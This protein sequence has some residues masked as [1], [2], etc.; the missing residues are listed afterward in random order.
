MFKLSNGQKGKRSSH[1]NSNECE[2]ESGRVIFEKD[3]EH[4][5]K[6]LNFSA[7]QY[8]LP[9]MPFVFDLLRYK[10]EELHTIGKPTCSTSL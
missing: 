7:L 9:S 5:I 1:Q 4:G 6:D 2:V 3:N 10:S 8:A